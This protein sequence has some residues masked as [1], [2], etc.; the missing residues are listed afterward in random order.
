MAA[1]Q[2]VWAHLFL[3][4]LSGQ[5]LVHHMGGRLKGG[6]G[7]QRLLGGGGGEGLVGLLRGLYRHQRKVFV[8]IIL[9]LFALT[10]SPLPCT[11][12]RAS[13]GNRFAFGRR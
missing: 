3:M 10:G 6:V 11:V 7:S 9:A 2:A 4:E 13:G 8:L 12:V 5:H 1:L